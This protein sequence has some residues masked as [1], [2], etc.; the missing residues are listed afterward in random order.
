FS[1]ENGKMNR[2]VID[3]G[4]DVLAIS[5]FTLLADCR[6]GRRPAFTDAAPPE[7]AKKLYEHFVSELRK[8]GLSVPCG[9]F[10]ADMAVSLTNDGPVT[11]ILEL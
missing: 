6:K 4:G 10:A 9:I 2:N 1:D 3:A 11:I 8:T 5:Q 7:R